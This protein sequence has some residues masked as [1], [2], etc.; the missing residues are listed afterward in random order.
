MN[1][2]IKTL[3]AQR[4]HTAKLIADYEDMQRRLA[5]RIEQKR[6]ELDALDKSLEIATRAVP[7]EF[8][9]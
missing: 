7:V 2:I 8:R 5:S 6:R 3:R 9:A 4:D 1:E